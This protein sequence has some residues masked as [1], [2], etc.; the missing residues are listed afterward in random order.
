MVDTKPKDRLHVQIALI[1][2]IDYPKPL[3][4][5]GN[6]EHYFL[7][8]LTLTKIMVHHLSSLAA[9]FDPEPQYFLRTGLL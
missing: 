7:F 4:I 2:L 5:K 9:H 6:F 8:E 3:E 1:Y